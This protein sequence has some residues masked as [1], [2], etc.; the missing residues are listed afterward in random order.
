MKVVT[1]TSIDW[2]L[3]YYAYQC[4]GVTP[5]NMEQVLSLTPVQLNLLD[6]DADGTIAIAD[7]YYML[8]AYS[9]CFAGSGTPYV[10]GRY[11]FVLKDNAKVIYYGENGG[12]GLSAFTEDVQQ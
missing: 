2:A 5:E 1:L 3:S 9:Y 6:V 10:E 7:A 4:A 11:D 8:C 12:T